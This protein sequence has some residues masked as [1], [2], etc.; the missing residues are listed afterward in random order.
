MADEQLQKTE[1]PDV[2]TDPGLQRVVMRLV[3]SVESGCVRGEVVRLI[4]AGS[5]GHLRLRDQ[6]CERGCDT[7]WCMMRSPSLEWRGFK[8][9]TW[10]VRCRESYGKWGNIV[11]P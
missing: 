5:G 1:G 2:K 11:L 3:R 10:G 7:E 8:P 4:G 9:R 6:Q